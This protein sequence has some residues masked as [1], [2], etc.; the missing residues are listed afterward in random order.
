MWYSFAEQTI[1]ST[2][3]PRSNWKCGR[4]YQPSTISLQTARTPPPSNGVLSRFR[5]FIWHFN[6]SWPPSCY[7]RNLKIPIPIPNIWQLHENS[8]PSEGWGLW[9]DRVWSLPLS[10][11][12]CGHQKGNSEKAERTLGERWDFPDGT[13]KG[14]TSTTQQAILHGR[15]FIM[16]EETSSSRCYLIVSNPSWHR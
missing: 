13:G 7:L 16:V 1:F 9:V 3:V 6:L 8:S 14:G 12:P 5:F 10:W 4:S 15:S 11:I 2:P